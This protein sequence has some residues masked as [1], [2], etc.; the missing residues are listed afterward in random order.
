[1]DNTLKVRVNEELL[2]FY[3]GNPDLMKEALTMFKRSKEKFIAIYEK[4]SNQ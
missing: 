3:K 1:M 4:E 2:N